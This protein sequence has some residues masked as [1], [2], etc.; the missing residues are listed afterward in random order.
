MDLSPPLSSCFPL[1]AGYGR[2]SQRTPRQA[3]RNKPSVRAESLA[4][5]VS[6]VVG[7][8]EQHGRCDIQGRVAEAPR[9][10]GSDGRGHRLGIGAL[11]V[12]RGVG[13]RRGDDVDGDRTATPLQGGGPRQA[14]HGFWMMLYPTVPA[15]PIMPYPDAK[16]M[17]RP[18]RSRMCGKRGLHRPERP[19]EP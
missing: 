12:V 4:G 17:N 1:L 7:G 8:E 14:A 16:L 5:D 15:F 10:Y 2:C 11:D 13:S 6:A 9:G 18:P 3:C 19:A